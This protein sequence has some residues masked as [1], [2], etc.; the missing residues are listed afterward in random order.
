MAKIID[1]KELYVSR[2]SKICTFCIHLSKDAAL[3]I[4]KCDAFENIP[5]EIWSG[6]NNHQ[7]PYPG[8]NGI[9]F[10]KVAKK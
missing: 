5:D 7:K 3:G 2:Y 8:D 10:E 9:Q 4:H 1:D 6:E